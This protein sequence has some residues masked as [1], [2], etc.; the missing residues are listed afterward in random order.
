MKVFDKVFSHAPFLHKSIAGH[1]IFLIHFYVLLFLLLGSSIIFGYTVLITLFI[2]Y[3]TAF[4]FVWAY[5]FFD[6]RL[7]FHSILWH[8]T[9]LTYVLLLPP[10]LEWYFIVLGVCTIFILGQGILSVEKRVIIN[11]VLLG[12][13]VVMSFKFYDFSMD[14]VLTAPI[15]VQ[16]ILSYNTSF[17]ND[18]IWKA[19]WDTY[20]IIAGFE[21][22]SFI[23]QQDVDAYKDIINNTFLWS[24]KDLWH[25]DL[26]PW[27]G[28]NSLLLLGIAYLVLSVRKAIN[29]FYP[30]LYVG[31]YI[32]S[33]ILINFL[34]LGNPF[35]LSELIL[36]S[37]SGVLWFCAIFLITENMYTPMNNKGR[38]ISIC[39]TAILTFLL[40]I[41]YYTP[42][43]HIVALII[44]NIGAS[45]L[46]L[47]NTSTI[48][49]KTKK[50]LFYLGQKNGIIE[51]IKKE[52]FMRLGMGLVMMMIGVS[53]NYFISDNTFVQRE[54]RYYYELVKD[55]F[56]RYTIQET[57][58]ETKKYQVYQA[59]NENLEDVIIV[60][61]SISHYR[62]DVS[63]MVV[64]KNDIIDKISLINFGDEYPSSIQQ[65]WIQKFVGLKVEDLPVSIE[66]ENISN[67]KLWFYTRTNIRYIF[68]EIINI[69][70][71]LNKQQDNKDQ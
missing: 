60:Y 6:N 11:P 39:L 52:Y 17:G 10:S 55:I 4:I 14:K 23:Y 5:H 13:L 59:L 49:G 58:Q 15:L 8:N 61:N 62:G 18:S 21:N 51:I 12:L 16:S 3:I 67:R 64:I 33:G 69:K 63:L 31:S 65:L 2:A 44:T 48:F 42:I 19:W 35:N 38:M 34:F 54:E 41:R 24:I 45:L 68:E 43:N 29:Y 9:I 26:N 30:L 37:S 7:F 25:S 47:L 71:I 27:L 28:A 32:I 40:H 20:H 57:I 22:L 46:E 56:P 50:S 36:Y 53:F 1:H 66:K 70:T